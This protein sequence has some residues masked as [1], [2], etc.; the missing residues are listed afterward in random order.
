MRIF[1][2]KARVEAPFP[3]MDKLWHLLT[4]SIS[5]IPQRL[6]ILERPPK[7]DIVA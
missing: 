1:K 7:L 2:G 6:G 3:I 5:S 4:P